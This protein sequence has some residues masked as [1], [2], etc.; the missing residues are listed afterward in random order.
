[1]LAAALAIVA[2]AGLVAVLFWPASRGLEDRAAKAEAAVHSAQPAI[3]LNLPDPDLLRPLSPEEARLEN[4]KRPFA[5]APGPPPRPFT[6]QADAVSRLRA[7]D[8]LTQAVYYEAASEG[9]EGGR[10][11]AQVVLNR[12]RHPAYPNT[13]CG[14]VYQGSSRATGCQF[15]FTCDGSLLRAPSAYLWARSRTIAQ[16]AL[17]GRIYGPVSLATH[18]HADYV[19]PYWADSLN[20][21]VQIGRHIF[22]GLKG[23]IGSSRAF[24]QRYPGVEPPPVSAGTSA[25]VL[26]EALQVTEGTVD[27]LLPVAEEATPKPMTDEQ[28]LPTLQPETSLAV[29]SAAGA[30]ILDGSAP[31]PPAPTRSKKTRGQEACSGG[32]GKSMEAVRANDLRIGKASSGC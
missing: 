7:I 9:V 29:D 20:K 28:P 10:A 2:I 17:A 5:A 32:S 30:L 21:L 4:E 14:V 1:V 13:V 8:C 18:Y 19:L 3:D 12:V 15:T 25:A 6:L 26:E 27:P 22:Y 11:V 16:E 24:N 31:P 23:G